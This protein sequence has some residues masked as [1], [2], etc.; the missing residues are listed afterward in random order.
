MKQRPSLKARALQWLAQRE[1]SRVELRRKLLAYASQQADVMNGDAAA[2]D[3][4]FSRRLPPSPALQA[5]VDAMLDELAANGHLSE[6]RFVEARVRVRAERHGNLRIRQE[7]A[8]HGLQLA[9]DDEQALKES[10]SARA[11]QV[12]Q[13]KFGAPASDAAGRARQARFLAGRGFPA[14]VV[15]RVLRDDD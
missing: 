11:K 9:P 7:L 10:E 15:R 3:S 2:Q 14:D 13:R 6:S 1:H 12:L 5:S 4:S 8:Q